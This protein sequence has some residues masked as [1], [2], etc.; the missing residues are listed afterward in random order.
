MVSLPLAMKEGSRYK[1]RT[2]TVREAKL[3]GGLRL[4]ASDKEIEEKMRE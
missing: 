3:N 1:K 4:S 2:L